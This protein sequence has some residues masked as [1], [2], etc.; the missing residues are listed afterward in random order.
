M[1]GSAS[2]KCNSAKTDAAE[3][4]L[5]R[6]GGC[7]EDKSDKTRAQPLLELVTTMKLNI[8]GISNLFETYEKTLNDA[9]IHAI[10]ECRIDA[11]KKIVE[12]LAPEDTEESRNIRD[13]L[14]NLYEKKS[15]DRIPS[16]GLQ[17][18]QLAKLVRTEHDPKNYVLTRFGHDVAELLELHILAALLDG[19]KGRTIRYNLNRQQ[20][21]SKLLKLRCEEVNVWLH[22]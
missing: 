22:L 15:I 7:E 13:I 9:K 8:S 1:P 11:A 17:G 4:S 18:L 12:L 19:E 16:D 21:S 3:A 14:M 2:K 10:R 20:Y 5:L 6:K